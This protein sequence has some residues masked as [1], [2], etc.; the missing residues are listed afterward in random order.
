[1]FGSNTAAALIVAYT[2]Q[3]AAP[4]SGGRRVRTPG[5]L[6]GWSVQLS[7]SHSALTVSPPPCCLGSGAR[8]R[9][10]IETRAHPLG[11]FRARLGMTASPRGKLSLGGG[12]LAR[13]FR[14]LYRRFRL[15][16]GRFGAPIEDSDDS[17]AASSN[18]AD[19]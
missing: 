12:G 7:S 11:L 16:G 14:T 5:P 3:D 9:V 4:P 15:F 17:G 10:L 1:M 18:D 13:R 19:R 8:W 6:S 2:V